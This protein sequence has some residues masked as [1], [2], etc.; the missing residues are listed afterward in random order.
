MNTENTIIEV[1][2]PA[3]FLGAVGSSLVLYHG[4]NRRI[5]NLNMESFLTTK[6]E[7]AVFFAEN[8]GGGMVY[9][10]NVKQDEVYRDIGTPQAE[11][12]LSVKKLK[13]IRCWSV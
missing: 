10:F 11:W 7:E 9:Q 12:Y 13:P 2:N 3:C 4:T 6:I 1:A 8:K 5:A